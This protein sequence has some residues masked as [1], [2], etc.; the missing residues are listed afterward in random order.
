[1][2]GLAYL[3]AVEDLDGRK[4]SDLEGMRD[5]RSRSRQVDSANADLRNRL[6]NRIQPRLECRNVLAAIVHQH[7]HT[8]KTIDGLAHMVH[9]HVYHRDAFV[10]GGCQQH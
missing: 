6:R 4:R 9:V 1:M 7:Y 8:L 5:R 2:I 3:V 10:G